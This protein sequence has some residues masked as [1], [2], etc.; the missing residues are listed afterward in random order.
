MFFSNSRSF[1]LLT[2]AC[3]LCCGSCQALA[4]ETAGEYKTDEIVVT[5]TRTL[6][7]VSKLPVAVEVI[8]RQQIEESGALNLE[9][10]LSEAHDVHALEPTNG[11]LGVARLRG[12]DSRLTLV[13]IDGYRLPSGF[14]GYVDLREIPSGIIERIEIVRGAGSTLYGSDAVGGVVNVITRQ[15]TRELHGGLSVS[16]GGSRYGQA[17]TG[18]TDGWLSGTSGKLGFSVAGSYYNRDRYDRNRSDLMTDGDD[19]VIGSGSTA[20][21]Y[22]LTPGV[23]ISAGLIYTDNELDGVRTTTGDFDRSVRSDRLV[24]YAG[25]DVKTGSES[26]LSLRASRSTYD[27]SSDMANAYGSPYVTTSI[28]GTTKTTTETSTTTLTK[29]VQD[30]DQFDARWTGRLADVHLL[31]AGVE[32]RTEYR[33]DYSRTVTKKVVTRTNATTGVITGSPTTTTTNDV[34]MNSHDAD[35]L[36]LYLQDEMAVCNPLTVIAG[37]RYDDHSDFGSELSPRVAALLRLNEHLKLRASYGEGFRA[38]SLYELYTGSVTTKK[39]IVLANSG[40]DAEISRT[41]ELG[42]DATWGHFDVG[43]T[44]FRNEI[45]NMI[46]QVL[47]DATTTPATYQ[48][49]NLT[50][51]MTRGL[52]IKAA[53]RLPYGFTL[54]DQATILDTENENTGKPLLFAPDV[55]NI[56]RIDGVNKGLGLRGNVRVVTTGSQFISDNEQAGGYSLVNCYLSKSVSKRAELFA[57]ADNLFNSSADASYGNNEGAGL[58]GTY[59]YG[60][61]NFRW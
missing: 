61:V 48:F 45:R 14:Q 33:E 23:K 21:T 29:V 20:I 24:G 60:G 7:P 39:S 51:A 50:Q 49:R 40:L 57:G 12:L 34:A 4:A 2:L 18:A 30:S 15:A 38:P 1:R 9:D 36:G 28:S 35:N 26:S 52:E 58:T 3:I 13:L 41:Y 47:V 42:A 54:S 22:A 55:T 31:T 46:S 56:V 53:L 43:L 10:V 25:V 11:R 17:G 16:G 37:L 6:N 32:Y 27:W 19:R 59:V 5:A 8:T 44:G